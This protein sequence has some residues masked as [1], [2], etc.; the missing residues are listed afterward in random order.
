MDFEK[1]GLFYLGREYDLDGKTS[2]DTPILYD[3]RDLVTHAVCVGMTGSGKTG[4]CLGLI[5]E[6]ALDGVPVIAIDPKGDLGNLLLTF[7]NLAPGDFRPW[8]DEEEARRAGQSADAYAEQQARTWKEGLAQWGQDGARIER[9]RSAAEFAIY[10]PGSRAGLGVSV[11]SSFAAP[12]PAVREDSES[13]AERAGNTAT[14]VLSLAGVDAEPRSR[15]HT[16]LATLFAAAWAAGTDLDLAALIQQVQT[17]PFQKVGILDLDAFFPRK[18]R[19]D[20]ALQLN[21][22]LAAPGFDQWFEGEPLDLARLLRTKDGKPRVSIF[23]IAHLGDAERMF[24]VSLLLN[25]VVSWMRGQTGTSS[26]RAIIYMD[27]IAGYFPP[28]ANPPSKQPLLT[29]LKQARGF[30]VGVVLATQNPVDLDYKGLANTGTWFIG[31]LQTDR[32]KARLL[33][34]LEGAAAGAI[35]RADADRL[36][37]ALPK[38][39]F[40]LHNV[41]EPK[42]VVFQTRWTMSYLRGP[43]SR[44]Q[45]KQVQGSGV[46]GS[47]VRGS[48]VQGARGQGS[49]VHGSRGEGVRPILPPGIEQYFVP[50]AAAGRTDVSAPVYA[51]VVLGAARVV[52][53]DAKLGVDLSRDVV[54]A[55]PI[56]EGPVAVDWQQAVPLDTPATTLQREPSSP[57]AT[58]AT[59]PPAAQQ[60]RSYAAWSK[61]FSQWL[62]QSQRLSLMRH[63]ETRLTSAPGEEERDFK[64]RVQDARRATRDLAVDAVRKKFATKRDALAERLRKAGAAIER[65]QQQA[66]DSRTQT[67]LSFGAAALGAVLGRKVL[68]SGT[69]G[70][71]TTAARGVGRSMK[72]AG[73][74][75]RAS[76]TAESLRQQLQELDDSI[77]DETQRIGAAFDAP[78][79]IESVQVAP[80]RGH[81][82]VQFVALGW[83]P[84]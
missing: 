17:P 52:F 38:R 34:G 72:E 60:P 15:E 1:L 40:L 70:R 61:S 10:T 30:G 64:G 41:H 55:A 67:M 4:L 5:E 56:L 49:S 83:Q 29:L 76:E 18:D 6:A 78:V 48:Q 12:P 8:V 21:G 46:Q 74:V 43:M 25:Q 65:E 3:S 59:L 62:S 39:V 22:I 63:A 66:T 32:D 69:I 42:P 44:E 35:D 37:S 58:F 24:F 20:L 26:L 27:E 84:E 14:S 13:L 71:A 36:L 19:F 68:N 31:R 47:E 9:L 81:V 57:D 50:D 2:T 75:K 23:S 45:I 53:T 51:P 80:K 28:V 82:S 11:L 73:D 77:R 16:L 79:D 33:D 54:F 7:P